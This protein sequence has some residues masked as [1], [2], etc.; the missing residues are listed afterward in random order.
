MRPLERFFPPYKL[1]PGRPGDADGLLRVHQRAILIL[2]RRVYSDAQVE[3]WACGNTP[4]RYIEAMNEDGEAFEVAVARKTGVV[5]FCSRK[6]NEVRGLYVDPDWT[7][8]G[9]GRLLLR[10]AEAAITAAGHG[11]VSIGASLTGLPFYEAEGYRVIRHRHWKTRG[12]LFIPAAE[13]EKAVLHNPGRK[14][15]R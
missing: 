2:G 8:H 15:A 13:M 1:R 11:R 7:R 14:Q 10:R 4:D 12:G 6:D 3:S 5:A 9:L